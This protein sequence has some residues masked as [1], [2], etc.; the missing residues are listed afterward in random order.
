MN[1]NVSISILISRYRTTAT[2]VQ[3]SFCVHSLFCALITSNISKCIFVQYS[4][5]HLCTVLCC[6]CMVFSIRAV[7]MTIESALNHNDFKP[8]ASSNV[9]FVGT[10]DFSW[11]TMLYLCQTQYWSIAQ[12]A[13]KSHLCQ[14]PPHQC[15][16]YHICCYC[17]YQQ[18]IGREHLGTTIPKCQCYP[19]GISR[20]KHL[21]GDRVRGKNCF[22]CCCL[23]QEGNISLIQVLMKLPLIMLPTWLT[24]LL[25][26]MHYTI[27]QS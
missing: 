19:V 11:P 7:G 17:E 18:H 2:Y 4:A 15:H 27:H 8:L 14:H 12:L 6:T 20:W 22:Q 3:C 24:S 1:D 16:K 23:F 26:L 5:V 25:S 9:A 10:N 21:V 13:K